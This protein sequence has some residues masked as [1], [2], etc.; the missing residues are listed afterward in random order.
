LLGEGESEESDQ[1]QALSSAKKKALGMA[2]ID[3]FQRI[4]IVLFPNDKTF[5]HLK[6]AMPLKPA[7][8]KGDEGQGPI[9]VERVVKQEPHSSA[10]YSSRKRKFSAG[11][12]S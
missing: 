3:A 5:L 10:S 7:A 12:S 1:L 4:S 6:D 11:N 8:P 9:V 2:R